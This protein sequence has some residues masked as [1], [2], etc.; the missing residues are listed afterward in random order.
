MTTNATTRHLQQPRL[1][2]EGKGP[3]Y[4]HRGSLPQ[5]LL[6][7]LL[8]ALAPTSWLLTKEECNISPSS[9]PQERGILVMAT[10]KA[11]RVV[12]ALLARVKGW[13]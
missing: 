12:Q 2:R 4:P 11:V 10:T 1:Q 8:P 5:H 9:I 7:Q 6:V 3:L 13:R